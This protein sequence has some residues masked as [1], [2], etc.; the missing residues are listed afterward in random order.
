ML[1]VNTFKQIATHLLHTASVIGTLLKMGQLQRVSPYLAKVELRCSCNERAKTSEAQRLLSPAAHSVYFLQ[2]VY[3]RGALL[4]QQ[5]T[6]PGQVKSAGR[7]SYKSKRKV[8]HSMAMAILNGTQCPFGC[9]CAPFT[10]M[11]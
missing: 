2:V 6:A 11:L 10:L 3:T 7:L 1:C 8:L 5:L 4:W 9:A